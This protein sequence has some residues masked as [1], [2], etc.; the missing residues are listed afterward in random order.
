MTRRALAVVLSVALG[1]PLV[2]EMAAEKDAR[3]KWWDDARFGIFVTWGLYSIPAGVW[4]DGRVCKKAYGEWI[5]EDLKIPMSRYERLADQWNPQRW[6]PEKLVLMAK[7]A[8]MKYLVFVT[9]FHDGL[10]MFDTQQSP[11]SVVKVTP[12][13][14][15]AFRDLAA[16]CHK[17]GLKLMPYYSIMDWHHPA[18]QPRPPFN[19][20]AQGKP[21]MDRYVAFMKAQLTELQQNYGGLSGI[22]FDGNWEKSWTEERGRDLD[23]F[24][25]R[26]IPGAILNN[27]VGMAKG[28]VHGIVHGD[29]ATPEE[30]IPANGMPGV[31]W[32]SA[33]TMNETWGYRKDDTK[34]K[35][36]TVM[37]RML[38]DCASKGGNLLLNVGPTAD[39]VIP[40]PSVKA[41]E[42]F[43]S[44]M[45][46]NA[47]AIQ[48]TKASPFAQSWRGDA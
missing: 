32:E 7:A 22:W 16:A 38:I 18:W 46:V 15:D 17:H 34:W 26:L 10:S 45:K 42:Q 5:M 1:L 47:E 19:D 41:L 6:D 36:P 3:M 29:F 4:E 24:C 30:E 28:G 20:T 9:K 8:G 23:E 2:A 39:G 33:M 37:I 44:W 48:G 14:R 43:A 25:R 35:T 11:Y 31:R 21:D 27:R 40:E 12:W 13:K